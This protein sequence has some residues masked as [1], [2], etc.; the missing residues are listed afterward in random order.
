[1]VKKSFGSEKILGPKKLMVQNNFG[2]RSLSMTNNSFSY[3]FQI[4]SRHPPDT[5]QTSSRQPPDTVQ[6]LPYT[7]YYFP[8]IVQKNRNF[9][10]EYWIL[11]N[12]LLPFNRIRIWFLN[13]LLPLKG[14]RIRVVKILLQ[15][16][17]NRIFRFWQPLVELD[18][19]PN[20]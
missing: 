15:Q 20:M 3:T 9:L 6:N 8:T 13:I 17:F 12:I 14:S 2:S 18:A 16:N 4:P 10:K 7:V 5:L 1:M 19:P 11:R